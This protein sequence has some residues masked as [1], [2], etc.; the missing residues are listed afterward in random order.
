MSD[1]CNL[2]E[3]A[4]AVPDKKFYVIETG[5]PY[6]KGGHAPGSM[7]PHP[8]FD[9]SPEGQLG[10]LRAIAYTVKHGLWGRGAGVCWWGTEYARFC[11]GDECAGFWDG[12]YTALPVLAQRGFDAVDITDPSDKPDQAVICPPL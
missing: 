11:S 2:R 5:Y 7:K 8:E 9:V 1:L 3:L 4:Q 10:W 12:N 6:K